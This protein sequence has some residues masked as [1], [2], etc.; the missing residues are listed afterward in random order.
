M[1]NRICGTAKFVG[2][3]LQF[4]AQGWRMVKEVAKR[5]KK[6]PRMVVIAALKRYIRSQREKTKN[7]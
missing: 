4:D 7:A 3:R 5:A 1:E 6:S 2:N